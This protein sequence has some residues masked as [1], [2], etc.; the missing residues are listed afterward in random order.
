MDNRPESIY[1]PTPQDCKTTVPKFE[2]VER[3][4]M[5]ERMITILPPQRE[6]LEEVTLGHL[7]HPVP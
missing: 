7:H 1:S 5:K 3:E 2:H 6:M 4:A